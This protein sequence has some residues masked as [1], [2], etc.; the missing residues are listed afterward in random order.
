MNNTASKPQTVV[1]DGNTS[2]A[3][4]R[5]RT[6]NR[7]VGQFSAI[8][9]L[10]NRKRRR[11][12]MQ[13]KDVFDLLDQVSKGAFSVFNKLKYLRSESNNLT[14]Y[15]DSEAMSKTD[16]EVLSRRIRELKN[17]D[18]IRS[19]K[20]EIVV[21]GSERIYRFQDP[22]KSFMINPYLIRCTEHDE[23]VYLWQQCAVPKKKGN[24]ASEWRNR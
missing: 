15:D 11:S 13:E 17:V 3:V 21:P 2:E 24:K 12:G 14:Q 18:L 8:G 4:I 6:G 5:N 7:I 9:P 22:R 20:K 19:M 23:A 16:K 1:F 10:T